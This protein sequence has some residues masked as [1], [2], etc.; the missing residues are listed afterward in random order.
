MDLVQ[1]KSRRYACRVSQNEVVSARARR[2][3]MEC[4]RS[5]VKEGGVAPLRPGPGTMLL[6]ATARGGQWRSI[7]LGTPE[8]DQYE[9]TT[10]MASTGWR[11]SGGAS[12]G[13]MPFG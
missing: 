4:A 7:G 2:C 11:L 8:H 13:T 5:W 12:L 10:S 1:L 3:S 9:V 6:Q